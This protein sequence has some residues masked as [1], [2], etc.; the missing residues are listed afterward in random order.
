MGVSISHYKVYYEE[1]HERR[2]QSV[3]IK[4]F[5]AKSTHGTIHQ[6]HSHQ[7]YVFSLSVLVQEL[8][9]ILYEINLTMALEDA[10]LQIFIPSK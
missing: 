3:F 1:Q 5:S 4:T 8:D 7:L 10:D 9:G 6:L 2:N